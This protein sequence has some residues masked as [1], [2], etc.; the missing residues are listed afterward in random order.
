V[1]RDMGGQGRAHAWRQ[2]ARLKVEIEQARGQHDQQQQDNRSSWQGR[3]RH[4]DE[5]Q[6]TFWQEHRAHS[7]RS[8]HHSW[9][10]RGGYRAYRIPDYQFRVYFGPDHPFRVYRTRVIVVGG[11]PRFEY[12]GLW[13]SVVDPVPEYWSDN[14]FD[15]DDVYIVYTDDGYYLCNRDYPDDRIAIAVYAG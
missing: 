2:L 8:E 15:D 12:G 4:G 5:E 13:F 3:D 14:W 9:R 10:E 11:Y 7:W 6:R 1:K